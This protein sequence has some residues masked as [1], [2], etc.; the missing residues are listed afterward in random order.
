M[1]CLELRVTVGSTLG[2]QCE[3]EALFDQ[4]PFD[5]EGSRSR[6][7]LLSAWLIAAHRGELVPSQ[8]HESAPRK[9]HDRTS[10]RIPSTREMFLRICQTIRLY[11]ISNG[12]RMQYHPGL[13]IWLPRQDTLVLRLFRNL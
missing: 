9:E 11:F 2:S 7:L 6:H 13:P 5:G 1:A 12:W 10:L 4:F 3:I 8:R